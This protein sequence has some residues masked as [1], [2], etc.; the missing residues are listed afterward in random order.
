[1]IRLDKL[2]EYTP[3]R[4]PREL[5]EDTHAVRYPVYVGSE[6]RSG[7]VVREVGREWQVASVGRPALTKSLAE[8]ATKASA[9]DAPSEPRFVVTMPALNLYFVGRLDGAML[10]LTPATD[11]ARFKLEAGESV[12]ASEL[13]GRVVPYAKEMRT[14]PRVVD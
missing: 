2:K 4:D 7:I 6:V 14:G 12:P 5:L 3:D 9:A 8:A 11:D 1:M 10:Q 13:F